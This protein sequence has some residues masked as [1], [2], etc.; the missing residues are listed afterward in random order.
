M[1]FSPNGWTNDE[2]RRMGGVATAIKRNLECTSCSD[3]KYTHL[4]AWMR[5]IQIMCKKELARRMMEI[6]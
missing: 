5:D 3:C 4:C 6:D 2:L 1:I